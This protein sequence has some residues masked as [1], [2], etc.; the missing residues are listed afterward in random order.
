MAGLAV[1]ARHGLEMENAL[2]LA[3]KLYVDVNIFADENNQIQQALPQ[4]PSSCWDSAE[5]LIK[6]RQIYEKDNVF[7]PTVIDGL[8]KI[9]KSYNDNDLSQRFY[10]K[11]DEIQKLVDR[12]LHFA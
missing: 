3:K 6:D 8:A 5:C 12:Y 11:N 2:E 7:P 9:L 10:G 4:L 1:A